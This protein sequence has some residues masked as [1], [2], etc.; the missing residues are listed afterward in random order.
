MADAINPLFLKVLDAC[1][2]QAPE[3]L[4]PK[5]FAIAENVDRTELDAA[6]DHL[7]H[8]GLIRFT[9]WV[10]G[11]GQGY[12]LTPEGQQVMENP[13]LLDRPLPKPKP[14]HER[15]GRG[16]DDKVWARGEKI[17]DCLIN[18]LT[19]IVTRVLLG[20]NIAVFLVGLYFAGQHNITGPY[21]TGH[22][23]DLNEQIALSRIYL[24]MGSL[25]P[26]L[27]EAGAWWR[28]ISHAFLH[29]GLLHIGL[30]MYFLFNIGALVESLWGSWRYCILYFVSALGGGLA[31]Y[32][33]NQNAIGASGA[34]CG[35]LLS[36][37]VWLFMSRHHL[38]SELVSRWQANLLTNVILLVVISFMPGVSWA[39]HLGGALAGAAVSFPLH[40]NRFGSGSLR[41][42]VLPVVVLIPA[43]I[44]G[45]IYFPRGDETLSI[46][47]YQRTYQHYREELE[48]DL[49]PAY[50]KIVVPML[51]DGPKAFEDKLPEAR[52][53]LKALLGEIKHLRGR[54]EKAARSAEPQI[55]A[56]AKDHIANLDA[57][58]GLCE[59]IQ[60]DLDNPAGW[61]AAKWFELRNR[62]TEVWVTEERIHARDA[63]VRS[64][65]EEQKKKDK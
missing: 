33:A 13:L 43:A 57:W 51:N 7:R 48:P 4:Y 32:L 55:Q 38:P 58:A 59:T 5:P 1:K 29:G 64:T 37:G 65:L 35:L 41:W 42:A 44:F 47:R 12:A 36:M 62:S 28:L 54:F 17:R 23:T 2:A 10:Q 53:Q 8:L 20:L 56:S 9:D 27:V 3:P 14:L 15:G 24:E 6:L 45:V 16:Q 30:N 60:K 49:I 25:V 50:N 63:L 40:I 31:A 46:P 18:P 52:E 61:D 11:M 19:P 34:L 26:P 39:A 22:P 21:L